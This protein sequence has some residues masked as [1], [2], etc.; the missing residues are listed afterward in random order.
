MA[1]PATTPQQKVAQNHLKKLNAGDI[2]FRENDPANSMYVVKRGRMKVF[3]QKGNSEVELATVGPGAMIGEMAFFDRKP[4]SASV[5]ADLDSEVIEL[6]F[7]SLEA[8]YK[9]LPEWLKSIVK[10]VN[11]HLRE[12][13]KRIKNLEQ[14]NE[15]GGGGS[16]GMAPHQANK[17][18]AILTLVASR[19][20]KPDPTDGGLELPAG[21]LRKFTIQVFQEPTNKMQ[22]LIGYLQG[23]N[24]MKFQDLGE[25]KVKVNLLKPEMLY[26]FV[27]WFNEW[28]F[29]SEDKKVTVE[30][31][32]MKPF[33]ALMFYAQK[34]T[35]IDAKGDVK[36]N[37]NQMQST[38]MQ[39]LSFLVAPNDYN[40][41]IKKGI[42]SEKMQE[43]DGLSVKVNKEKIVK[44]YNYWQIVH[45]IQG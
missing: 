8:Q 25:G 3:K 12:A 37:I 14:T 28:L 4:R 26:D 5:K 44:L 10:T 34:A 9:L 16:S 2:L 30:I 40:G 20:G 19:F 11:D 13:N 42:C 41:L 7:N 1:A 29:A 33:K 23:M 31:D 15:K 39:D 21:T 32:E 24:I 36:L 43:K 27:E 35:D 6:S 38:S 18:C 45:A 17:L 22:Q